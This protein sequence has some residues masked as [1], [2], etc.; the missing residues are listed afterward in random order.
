MSFPW[1]SAGKLAPIGRACITVAMLI[2]LGWGYAAVAADPPKLEDLAKQSADLKVG[3]DT[4]WVMFAGMLVFFMNAGFG[5]LET[6]LCRQK[7][8][9]NVLAKNLIVFALST[10]AFWAIGF[11]LMFSDG[12]PFIGLGGLFLQGADNSPAMGDAYKGIFSSLN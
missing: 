5:M 1:L 7:N 12:N 6:G 11:G 3:I 10:V 8:A 2:I 4:M 9:V